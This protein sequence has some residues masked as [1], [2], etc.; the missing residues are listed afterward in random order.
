MHV[1]YDAKE[2]LGAGH[3]PRHEPRDHGT[4]WYYGAQRRSVPPL[5]DEACGAPGEGALEWGRSRLPGAPEPTQGGPGRVT[6]ALRRP[7][8]APRRYLPVRRCYIA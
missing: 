4:Q 1:A 6:L 7:L 5:S 8:A 2:T 3:D